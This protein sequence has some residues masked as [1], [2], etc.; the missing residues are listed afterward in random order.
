[1]KKIVLVN[2]LVILIL[3]LVIELFSIAL[4]VSIRL[5]QLDD[6]TILQRYKNNIV[7]YI[8]NCYKEKDNYKHYDILSEKLRPLVGSNYQKRPIL[9]FGCS[10]TY[11]NLLNDDNNFSG[12]LSKVAQRP[13][14]NMAYD[15]WGPAHI[16]KQLREN[17]TLFL[18]DNPDYII[19]TYIK[20]HK[21]RLIFF[22]GWGFETQLYLRYLIDSNGELISI[23]RKYPFYWRFFTTKHLQHAIEKMKLKNERKIDELMF[24][25]F[26]H[27]ASVM[28]SRYPN[29]KLV[30]LLYNEGF[31]GNDKYIA[32][33]KTENI[34]TKDEQEKFWRMGFEIINMEELIGKS[35]CGEEYHARCPIYGDIDTCH[36][37][38]KMWEEF[39]PKLVEKLGM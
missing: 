25:L 11:G 9:L 6:P 39:V 27:S 32:P 10:V 16:L 1:M 30:M 31:C 22:Q 13:V 38:S 20:D 14:Y 8:I 12:I 34:L 7:E 5:K 3:L 28:K 33:V 19:Y 29:A 17:R 21:K 37:S 18:V 4:V 35:L 36:P 26:E 23:P 2:F 15:G 24:Y